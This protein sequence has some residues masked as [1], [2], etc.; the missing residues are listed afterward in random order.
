MQALRP[1]LRRWTW[2]AL[3][4]VLGLALA[5]TVSHALAADGPRNAFTEIC[6][7]AGGLRSLRAEAAESGAFLRATSGAS[8]GGIAGLWSV[9]LPDGGVG[10][11]AGGLAD[12]LLGHC[13]LCALAAG[14][15]VLPGAEPAVL[16]LRDGADHVA[17]RFDQAPRPLFAWAAAQARAPPLSV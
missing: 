14:Q 8:T 11:T 17:A 16:P 3:F 4:A 2:A 10:D 6:S 1:F 5:P 15:A 7:A 13:P 12:P 9:G